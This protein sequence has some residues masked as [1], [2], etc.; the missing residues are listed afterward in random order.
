[1]QI[2]SLMEITLYHKDHYHACL[3]LFDSNEPEHFD[4][5]ER[6]HFEEYLKRKKHSYWV[7]KADD[8]LMACG[9]Y[10]LEKPGDARIV[11]LMVDQIFHGKGIGRYLMSHIEDQI[12]QA[13]QFNKIS[14]MTAQGANNFYE[15]LGYSTLKFEPKYWCDRFDLYYMEKEVRNKS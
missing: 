5:S 14:L 8:Q 3:A 6:H 9:G 12:Q 1:M 2:Y 10:E 7:V 15:K 13:A 11:W 4:Q